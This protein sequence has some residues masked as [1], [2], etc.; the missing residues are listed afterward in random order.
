MSRAFR[1][2]RAMVALGVVGA[3]AAAAAYAC[4][5]ADTRPPPATLLVNVSPG[6]SMDGGITTADGW[7]VTFDRVY[8]ALGNEG[9]SDTCTVYGEADYNRVINLA[10]GP[11]Q[12]L[13]ILHGI[14]QCDLRLRIAPPSADSVLGA[15]VTEDDRTQ[16]EIP[17][18][19]P[20][21]AQDPRTATGAGTAIDIR[22][23]AVRGAETKRF[24][25]AYRQRIRYQRCTPDP[26]PADASAVQ[27]TQTAAFDDAGNP[28]V[29]L[30]SNGN[31]VF[32]FV[33]EPE[34]MFRDDLNPTSAAL[35]FD[36]F[37]SAD[38]NGDGLITLDELTKV[39][40]SAIR[41][42][43]AFEAGTYEIDDAGLLRRGKP[44]VIETLGDFVYDLVVPTLL[45]FQRVGWC[46]ASVGRPRPN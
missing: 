16:M 22:G 9:F 33:V 8:I 17:L 28:A 23:T 42:S 43:G 13:G 29:N 37:A 45:R 40:I 20:Y 27:L 11:N 46:V 19:D 18:P 39:P 26:P 15:Q 25:L 12:K 7:H 35:R 32:E 31:V 5:P 38:T 6:A 36:P 4:V 44:I 24:Q 10:A 1:A 14:G 30:A 41:D 3:A 34:A 2:F 21:V